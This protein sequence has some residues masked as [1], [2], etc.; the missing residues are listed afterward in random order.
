MMF[1]VIPKCDHSFNLRIMF[2]YNY[3]HGAI[4]S[5]MLVAIISMLIMGCH[6]Y[7]RMKMDPAAAPG[8]VRF[9]VLDEAFPMDFAWRVEATA[10]LQTRLEG[11]IVRLSK[12][13]AQKVASN[14]PNKIELTKNLQVVFL[15]VKNEFTQEL[16]KTNATTIN[17]PFDMVVRSDLHEYNAE[18]SSSAS[19]TAG[20]LTLGI[21]VGALVV[22]AAVAC[23]CPNIYAE[24][25]DEIVYQ[26]DIF[27]GA[28]HPQTE[29][30]DW[31]PLT[32]LRPDK[33]MYRLQMIN[34]DPEIQYI[35]LLELMAVDHPA[36]SVVL[37][38]KYGRLHALA[39]LESPVS[40]TDLEGRDALSDVLKEDNTPFR[41]HTNNSNPRAEDGLVLN[42]QRPPG[43]REAKL[44]IRANS[45]PWLAATHAMLQRDLGKYGPRV[46][47]KFLEK[48]S[49]A[50]QQWTLEQNIP[51]S[52]SLETTPGKW[53]IVDFFNLIGPKAPRRDV[54]QI[55]LSKVRGDQV[56][57]KLTSGFHFWEI[58]YVAMD[59]GWGPLVRTYKLPLETAVDQDGRDIKELLRADDAQYY[60]QP[61]TGDKAALGFVAP[62]QPPNVERSLLL[63]AKGYYRIQRPPMAGNPS[64]RFLRQFTQADAFPKYARERWN[65]FA[66]RDTIWV[67]PQNR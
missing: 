16:A 60:V 29:R 28:T 66:A 65:E 49:A 7:N 56:R 45:S 25:P 4:F 12:Q 1:R 38:D 21:P 14:Q 50:L 31:L 57:I 18:K 63:H 34:E 41:G 10:L 33:G 24:N 44:L 9:Y 55:D 2:T 8:L 54:L 30:H 52:V 59:F 6:T 35:N 51:L 17:L 27:P 67:V 64:R 26:G 37:Y 3:K 13:E 11:N 58:D 46:R 22:V 47:Q 19:Y 15:Y 48:D 20:L 42:F 40:A 23:S 62:V 39:Q 61:K 32:Q 53:E 5:L 43:V 36:G